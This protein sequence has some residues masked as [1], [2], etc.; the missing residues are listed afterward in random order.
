MAMT[1]RGRKPTGAELVERLEGSERAKSRL[2]LILQTISGQR[3]IADAC[4]E[5]GIQ[6]AMFYRVRAEA[7]QTALSRLEPRPLGRPH[8]QQP[9]HDPEREELEEENLRLRSELK[10]AEVRRELAENLPRLAKSAEGPGKKTT[11][12][13][14]N[15]RRLKRRKRIANLTNPPIR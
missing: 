4:E 13:E 8:H 2:K 12:S 7:L 5:L 15:R 9:A 1:R 14:V 3:T 10:A 6:E 11:R